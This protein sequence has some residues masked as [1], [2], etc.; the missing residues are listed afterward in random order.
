[1]KTPMSLRSMR[2][3]A[4]L[5]VAQLISWGTSFDMMGVMGRIIAPDLGLPNEVV[6]FGLSIMM[7]V[8][9]MAGPTTGRLL[10]RYGAAR[11]LS[12]ASLIFTV[13]LLLL[14]STQNVITY[15]LAWMVIGFGGAFGLVAPAYTAVVERE[16]LNGKRVIAILMLFTGLSATIFW[17]LL[18]FLDARIGWRLTYVVCAALHLFICLPLYVYGLPKP[19]ETKES[20]ASA[21]IVPVPLT[22]AER[23]RAF[24]LLAIAT[25][26][27]SFVSYGL[28]PS[29]LAL[30][31][32]SGARPELA[33]QLGSARGAIGVSARFVDMVLG[34]RGNAILTSTIGTA[35]TLLGFLSLAFLPGV[36][37]VLVIF[38]FLYSFGV[39]VNAVARALLPLT[40]FSPRE[41]GRQSARLS[42]P[43]NLANAAAPV[44]FTALLD[45][46]GAS[47]VLLTGAGL[48]AIAL[49]LILQLSRMVKVA[50]ARG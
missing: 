38:I 47:A 29:M 42:L 17:P 2:T 46:L 31:G 39:G 44:I 13:G 26:I 37:S 34:R 8:S 27:S 33:L 9:A 19:V 3:V 40:L 6:F 49:V 21:D 14:A 7:G 35:L 28:G 10:D 24:G 11:V 15:V 12:G 5:A 23:K 41:F 4:V 48:S 1:M 36:P 43:Q 45:R 30:L 18:S 22:A 16:G 50:Q 25:S 20:A 32:A